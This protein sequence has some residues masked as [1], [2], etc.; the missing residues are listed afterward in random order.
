MTV[1]PVEDWP[2]ANEDFA[3][4]GM[5]GSV[6]IDLVGNDFDA[7]GP[8]TVDYVDS[9]SYFGGTVTDNGDGTATYD[10]WMDGGSGGSGGSGGYSVGTGWD[11]FSDEIIDGEGNTASGWADI[12]VD[13]PDFDDPPIVRPDYATTAEDTPVT[14][15]ILS[16][17]WDD[18]G[19]TL[20]SVWTSTPGRA[21]RTMAT[22]RCGIHLHLTFPGTGSVFY[23]IEV[24]PD[25]RANASVA[26]RRS[27]ISQRSAPSRGQSGVDRLEADHQHF[28]FGRGHGRGNGRGRTRQRTHL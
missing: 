16:N 6:T 13:D 2:V 9:F 4:V 28:C 26:H 23:E 19:F 7:E 15:D 22:A 17:D 8:V 12:Y 18:Y 1:N 10:N 27:H 24:A 5:G 14:F 20:I 21:W 25:R 11:S 3:V